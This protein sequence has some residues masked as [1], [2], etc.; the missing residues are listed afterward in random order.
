MPWL[1]PALVLAAAA[2]LQGAP[3]AAKGGEPGLSVRE[4]GRLVKDGEPVRCIGVN[5]FDAFLRTLVKPGDTSYEEGLRELARHKIPLARFMCGGYWP[6]QMKA[7]QDNPPQYFER[8]DAVVKAAEKHGVGL[9]ASLFW[10]VATVPDLVGEPC[11]QWGNPK[12]KTHAFMRAYTRDVVT[13]YRDSPA[14]WGWEFGNEYNLPADLPNAADHRPPVQPQLGTPAA[15]TARDELT[16]D[17]VRTALAEFAKEVRR[18]DPHRIITSGNAYPRATAWHQRREKAWTSDTPEQSAE[19]LLGDNPD[20]MDVLSVHWYAEG[21]D[22]LVASMAVAARARKPLFVGEFGVPGPPS[23]E[24]E[25]RFGEMLAA[26]EQAG[27]PLAALWV[28]GRAGQ[29]GEWNVTAANARGYQLKAVAEANERIRTRLLELTPLS[30][31]GA[32]GG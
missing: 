1:V 5:Y 9:I 19:M 13:R 31:R 3:A 8:L 21:A 14:I 6:A 7:Y 22:R 30:R 16:H 11:D 24:T 27:V 15:R 4:D 18:H 26:I 12:S 28:Y 25:K 20:P 29:D 23:P 17:M 2:A 10:H 32:G